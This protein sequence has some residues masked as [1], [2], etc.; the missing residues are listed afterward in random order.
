MSRLH[1]LQ[2][3]GKIKQANG[4]AKTAIK[5][6]KIEYGHLGFTHACVD[7]AL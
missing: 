4:Q 5:S 3:Q 1:H 2:S 6:A 7:A